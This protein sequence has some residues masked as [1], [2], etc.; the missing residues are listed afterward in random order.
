[1]TRKWY[2]RTELWA[3]LLAALGSVIASAAQKLPPEW[4]GA[5]AT[6]AAV[7]YALSRGLAKTEH[8]PTPTAP[9]SEPT[10]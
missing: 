6:A 5:L 1:V 2:Q 3:T 7:A 8:V 10:P 4:A 9:P